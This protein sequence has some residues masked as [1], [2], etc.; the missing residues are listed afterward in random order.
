MTVDSIRLSGVHSLSSISGGILTINLGS[1][2][3]GSQSVVLTTHVTNIAYTG[4]IGN[5]TYTIK[6]NLNGSTISFTNSSTTFNATTNTN[7]SST[8]LLAKVNVFDNQYFTNM[9]YY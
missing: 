8:I 9:T 2:S 5:G 7:S 6:I 3:F 4:G 1:S